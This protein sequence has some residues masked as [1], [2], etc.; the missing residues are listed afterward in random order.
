[1]EAEVKQCSI[2]APAK[3]SVLV[4][5]D[6]NTNAPAEPRRD[7]MGRFRKRTG[8]WAV[9]SDPMPDVRWTVTVVS[10]TPAEDPN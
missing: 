6:V 4:R 10:V 3:G 7:A 9:V 1:L 5:C 2:V 8:I